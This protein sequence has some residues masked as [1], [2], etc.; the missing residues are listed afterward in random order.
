MKIIIHKGAQEI[1]GTCISLT[2]AGTT[3]WL[4]FGQPLK[5]G[6][7]IVEADKLQ[8]QPNAVFLSHAHLDHYGR[9]KELGTS[10][11]VYM[12]KLSHMLI[13]ALCDFNPHQKRLLNPI[14]NFEGF[15]SVN[16][17][18]FAITPWPV[19]HS[20]SDAYSFV[21]KAGGKT[22]FYSGD[23][24][25]HGWKGK[26]FKNLEAKLPRNLDLMF[27]EGTMFGRSEEKVKSESE[28]ELEMAEVFRR[29]TN[30]S[31]VVCSGQ[32]IDRTVTVIKACNR[33]RKIPVIGIYN[34]WLLEQFYQNDHQTRV[35]NLH[36][37]EDLEVFFEPKQKMKLESAK[38]FFGNFYDLVY[39]HHAFKKKQYN[40]YV[41]IIGATGFYANVVKKCARREKVKVHTCPK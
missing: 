20:A 27:L 7:R 2:E 41:M 23:L 10:I 25:A 35:P 40:A 32:N 15:E 14:K 36:K 9:I 29:Q 33:A 16:L 3:I 28:L 4:D 11:P 1:G 39:E 13:N 31:F 8:P 24:R 21:V 17:D 22:I 37:F 12:G 26:T 6:S 38:E 5:E 18:P 30:I 34:A 19:D